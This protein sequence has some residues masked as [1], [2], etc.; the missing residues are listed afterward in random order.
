MC[1][2]ALLIA[3]ACGPKEP[4]EQPQPAT[5]AE[6]PAASEPATEPAPAPAEPATESAPK[7]ETPS[8][9]DAVNGPPGALRDQCLKVCGKVAAKCSKNV[10]ENCELN[11]LK[12]DK[13]PRACESYAS[14]ALRCAE[15]AKD[16]PCAAMAPESCAKDYRTLTECERAPDTFQVKKEEKKKLPEGWGVYDEAAFSVPVPGGMTKSTAG[17]ESVWTATSGKIRY[18]VRKLPALTEKLTPKSQLRLANEWLKPCT[19]KMKLHGHVE[20]DDRSTLLYDSG[21]KDGGERHGM[22]YST[23][24]ALYIVGVEAPAGEK[25]DVETFVY[26][27]VLK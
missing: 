9:S 22:V 14:A 2:S 11:C 25:A 27:F 4:A 19:M 13:T 7:S 21:C 3:A 20:K 17:K 10:A 12:Y 1:I 15:G 8:A 23:P 6:A 24:N 16:L 26:G 5:T 18:V